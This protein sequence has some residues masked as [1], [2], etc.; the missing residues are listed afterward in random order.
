M[1]PGIEGRQEASSRRRMGTRMLI[2]K[3]VADVCAYYDMGPVDRRPTSPSERYIACRLVL[4]VTGS[5]FGAYESPMRERENM[6]VLSNHARRSHFSRPPTSHARELP[7][8]CFKFNLLFTRTRIRESHRQFRKDSLY[9]DRFY[10]ARTV[11]TF[12][13]SF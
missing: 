8:G 3:H 7:L 1:L 6:M 12:S 10:P 9:I 5:Y 11:R 4:R 13:L 2:G